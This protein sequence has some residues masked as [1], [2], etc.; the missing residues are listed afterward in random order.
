MNIQGMLGIGFFL[1]IAWCI[2]E[3]RRNVRLLPVG[4]TLAVQFLVAF[5]LIAIPQISNTLRGLNHIV[6]AVGKATD[7]ATSFMFGF[8]GGGDAPFGLNSELVPYIFAFRVLPQILVFSVIVA[9]LWHWKVLP[10]VIRGF[11]WFL[12][13][14]LGIR[15]AVGVAAASS[16]FVGSVESPMI[17]RAYLKNLSKS[18]L[19]VVMTCGM[20]TVAG[21]MMVA[22]ANI[23]GPV[24][25]G[26]M[27]HVLT[28]SVINV[29]GALMVARIMIPDD[30]S[31]DAHDLA[32]GLSYSSSVDA[33]TRGTSD[34]TRLVV[35]VGAMLIVLLSL[36]ALVNHI[37]GVIPVGGEPLSLERIGGWFFS[38]IVWLMGVPWADANQA[39]SYMAIKLILNE[40]AAYI[41]FGANGG[42]LQE[43]ARMILTYALCGFANFGS[44]GIV[45]GG[46]SALVPERRS[47]LLSLAPRTLISGT[48]VGCI[49]GAM[50]GLIVQIES[51][52]FG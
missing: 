28:A 25:D 15:G 35:N 50:V 16:I 43:Q 49:T 1:L 5:I 39:G 48:M 29:L 36:V 2:S 9:L 4:I 32:S 31:T 18:E 52:L 3:N 7:A 44:V 17:I 21:S 22:Y 42:N 37:I 19:F 23:L 26:A 10:N 46:I 34:G 13:R 6:M 45:I 41:D 40:V 14:T 38:P 30:S 47:D 51:F 33:L 24:I 12:R 11:A 8:L 27:G 20:S